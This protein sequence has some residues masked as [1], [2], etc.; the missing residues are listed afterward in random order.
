MRSDKV[1]PEKTSLTRPRFLCESIVFPDI[2]AIP[3]PSC[4][5]CCIARSPAYVRPAASSPYLSFMLIPKIR[6]SPL[7]AYCFKMFIKFYIV[8]TPFMASADTINRVPTNI[9]TTKYCRNNPVSKRRACLCRRC[10]TTN[11]RANPVNP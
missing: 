4:P 3:A 9:L 2:A 5:L 7:L 11:R 6:N 1:F 8:G 10:R